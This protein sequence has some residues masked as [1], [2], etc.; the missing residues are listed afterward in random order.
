MSEILGIEDLN[1]KA[2]DFALTIENDGDT[3]RAWLRPMIITLQ[4]RWIAGDLTDM[5]G[6]KATDV[7]LRRLSPGHYLR[8]GSMFG[9]N[10]LSTSERRDVAEYLYR[11]WVAEW[12]LG[13]LTD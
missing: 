8:F 4:R 12:C 10:R 6:I 2:R 9:G 7:M 5:D 3:Y 13:N 11:S 1:N